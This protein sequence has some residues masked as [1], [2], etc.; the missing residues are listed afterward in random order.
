MVLCCVVDDE[1]CVTELTTDLLPDVIII[2]V[3]SMLA[4]TLADTIVGREETGDDNEE[5]L[6]ETGV[7][8]LDDSAVAEEDAYFQTTLVSGSVFFDITPKLVSGGIIMVDCFVVS[9][10]DCVT[11]VETA[12]EIGRLVVCADMPVDDVV[13]V[14]AV[15]EDYV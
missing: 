14:V 13:V 3:V 10:E 9:V 4:V 15:A 8:Y 1:S 2:G 11:D 7:V 12:D 6:L 5:V